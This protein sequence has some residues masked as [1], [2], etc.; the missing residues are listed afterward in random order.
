MSV[1]VGVLALLEAKPEK[2]AELAA[3]LEQAREL[4]VAEQQTVSWY[5]FQA[6]EVTYGIFDTFE[7]DAGRQAHLAGEIAQALDE[8][9]ARPVGQGSGHPPGRADRGQVT[10]WNRTP[11]CV[12]GW[13][14]SPVPGVGSVAGSRSVSR[15]RA[16]TS[17]CSHALTHELADA[18]TEI[19][20][21]GGIAT[22]IVAD[23]RD[24]NQLSVPSIESA[25]SSGRRSCW[26]TTPR[27]SRRWARPKRWNPERSRR[28]WPSTWSRRST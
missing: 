21:G 5:A 26:S 19:E 16:R 13:R 10:P 20:T 2:A 14:W 24:D 9:R 4:A 12:T 7:T 27:W 1:S 28:R 8:G 18:V 15:L 6:D 17:R 25:P 11:I 22:A 23:V 3:L